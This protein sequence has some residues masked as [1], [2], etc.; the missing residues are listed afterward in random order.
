MTY[1]VFSF[2]QRELTNQEMRRW[3]LFENSARI[4]IRFICALKCYID[5]KGNLV[6]QFVPPVRRSAHNHHAQGRVNPSVGH[7]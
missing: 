1:F 6:I 4:L 5:I 3:L 2:L 7:P